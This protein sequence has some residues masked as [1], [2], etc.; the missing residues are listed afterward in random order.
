MI[1]HQ[2]A[3]DWLMLNNISRLSNIVYDDDKQFYILGFVSF[4]SKCLDLY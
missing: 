2:D 3:L 4:I 1:K